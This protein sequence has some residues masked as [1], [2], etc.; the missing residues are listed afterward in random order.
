VEADRPPLGPGVEGG[1]G[2][3]GDRQ[4]G[5][6]G[7]R[8]D[9]LGVGEAE[10]IGPD[11]GHPAPGSP[12]GPGERGIGAVDDHEADEVPD[13]RHEQRQPVEHRGPGQPPGVVDHQCAPRAGPFD[14][15]D[16]R[17][18]E[19]RIGRAPLRQQQA[20]L[21]V[22]A[23]DHLGQGAHQVGPEAGR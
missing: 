16:H 8:G 11:L 9:G 3:I 2:G 13:A 14:L 12:Q 1:D 17:V 19:D 5:E 23:V 4:V 20:G 22:D 10:I 18:E 21:G 6:G 15:G 7:G